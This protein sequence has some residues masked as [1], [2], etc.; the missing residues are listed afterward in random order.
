[1]KNKKNEIELFDNMYPV[2]SITHP[3]LGNGFEIDFAEMYEPPSLSFATMTEISEM[4]GTKEIDFDNYSHGGCE[5]CD[6]GSRY[7]YKIQVYK[8]TRNIPEV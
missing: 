8:A 5:T 7:G 3:E 6:Y 1:M 2:R 4:F